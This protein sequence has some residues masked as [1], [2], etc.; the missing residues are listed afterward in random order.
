MSSPAIL[1]GLWSGNQTT[2]GPLLGSFPRTGSP[3]VQ[4]TQSWPI[5]AGQSVRRDVRIYDDI[6]A[7][8]AFV[9]FI[10]TTQIVFTIRDRTGVVQLE[11]LADRFLPSSGW[12]LLQLVGID[13]A[14]LTDSGY[15]WDLWAILPDNSQ[16]PLTPPSPLPVVQGAHR[17]ADFPSGQTETALTWTT[18]PVA[19][20]SRIV[21]GRS[22]GLPTRVMSVGDSNSAGG[23]I[24][25]TTLGGWQWWYQWLC[26]R[27]GKDIFWAGPAGLSDSSP[28]GNVPKQ[29]DGLQWDVANAGFSG[30]TISHSGSGIKPFYDGTIGN[31]LSTYTPDVMLVEIGTNDLQAGGLFDSAVNT[32]ARF[33]TLMNLWQTLIPTQSPGCKI[34][35]GTVIPQP[36]AMTVPAYGSLFSA[37]TAL[38]HNMI[39]E[40]VSPGG[41]LA[42]SNVYLADLYSRIVA[43]QGPFG[44]N[45]SGSA[46]FMH[47][48][49][50][51]P[52][53]PYI[54]PT[55]DSI[56][57]GAVG[58]SAAITPGCFSDNLHLN[59]NA[60]Q[61]LVA[62]EFLLA[63]YAL[64]A[65]KI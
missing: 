38:Y 55:G 42:A 21:A 50:A 41:S 28:P 35:V 11:V 23:L 65:D 16:V 54:S 32:F 26:N 5:T 44:E 25:T 2:K 31:Y 29:I 8:M 62:E 15:T 56:A 4:T 46:D 12:F 52:T 19:R 6:G 10:E 18:G 59:H 13:T 37:Q 51:T 58:S 57:Y 27:L 36:G 1:T 20:R 30:A 61:R 34:V 22:A 17:F 9:G 47:S 33:T 64:L 3:V 39:V 45:Y 48:A 53:D 24:S 40:A 14:G 60:G 63:S 7:P 43:Y 49:V